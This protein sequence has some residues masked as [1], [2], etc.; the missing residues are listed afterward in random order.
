[1]IEDI[2]ADLTPPPV[3]IDPNWWQIETP[4]PP[5][6]PVKEMERIAWGPKELHW[7]DSYLHIYN[8]TDVWHQTIQAPNISYGCNTD[9]API[10]EPTTLL[11]FALAVLLV[12]ITRTK[13]LF[14]K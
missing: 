4:L 10:P 5:W 12:L 14:T 13:K 7:S 11:L 6:T 9:P 8:R 1:M 3:V 2:W